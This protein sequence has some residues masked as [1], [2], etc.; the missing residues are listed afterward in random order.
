VADSHADQVAKVIVRAARVGREEMGLE[1]LEQ[2]FLQADLGPLEALIGTANARVTRIFKE[3]L[4]EVLL[5]ILVESGEAAARSATRRGLRTALVG[6]SFDK[7][8][9]RAQRWA[10]IRAAELVAGISEETRL[11]IRAVIEQAFNDNIPP[12]EA[13]RLIRPLVG[14]SE[15]YAQAVLHLHRNLVR[16]AG[17]VVMA[18]KVRIRVPEGGPSPEFLE[19]HTRQY[20]ERLLVKRALNIAR[21]ETM[22]ASNEGQRELWLQAVEQ[23]SLEADEQREWIVTPDDRLCALCAP[24][25]GAV[26]PLDKPF[27]TSEGPVMGPPLHPQC[28]CAQGITDRRRDS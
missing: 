16:H 9:P 21:T 24:L 6:V 19:R 1:A 12:R 20:S 28:R 23:G 17:T 10:K 25:D 4:P 18:G 2:G 8:N 5:E 22:A 11:A 7:T 13:A 3:E 27:Q 14:L 15:P 26:A